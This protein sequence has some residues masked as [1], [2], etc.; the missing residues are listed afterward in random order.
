MRFEDIQGASGVKSAL[1]GM[2]RSGRVPHAL[3]FYEKDGGGAVQV[4]LAFLQH[5]Y[6]H[7]P[8]SSDS[9][10][11]CPSCNKISKLIHPDVHFIFPTV[12]AA[13]SE[14]YL[15]QWRSLVLENPRF[16]ENDLARAMGLESKMTAISVGESKEILST[17]SLSALEGGYRSVLVYLPEKLHP[18]AANRLLK[19][20]EEPPE[21]TQFI[22][23]THAPEKVLVTIAS[24]CQR[25]DVDCGGPER[26]VDF[27]HPELLDS[28]LEALFSRDL[29]AALDVAEAIAALPSRE[30]ARA[31]CLYGSER[32]R[33]L[34]LA[35]Q[36]IP[37]L[38]ADCGGMEK[39]CRKSF[40]RE[41]LAAF[42][43]AHKLV[44]RN[45][46][47]KILFTDLVGNLYTKV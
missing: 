36:G 33:R 15:D 16:T 24:R 44:V 35:Q 31:F 23:I 1:G 38:T 25:I 5:L 18:A 21:K 29:P 43:R 39:R 17:L 14:H 3:M 4:A 30:S 6:C 26:G 19:I 7:N 12:G 28:L 41:A 32:M 8:S 11:E 20:I 2:V 46:N 13:T 34:F 9:C 45:V 27:D 10:G 22:L 42:D 37:G 40:P 47:P